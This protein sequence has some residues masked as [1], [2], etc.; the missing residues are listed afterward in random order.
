MNEVRASSSPSPGLASRRTARA[1]LPGFALRPGATVP[2]WSVVA[3]QATEGALLAMLQAEHFLHRWQGF[4]PAEDRA[5]RSLLRLYTER[6]HAP[7][8][9]DL[10]AHTGIG[11]LEIRGLLL[12]LKERDLVVLDAKNENIVGAYPFTDRD[13]GHRV[14]LKG[15]TLNAMCAV[16]ALGVGDM[17]GTDIEIGSHCPVCGGP[18]DIATRD[19]GRALGDVRPRTI[20]VWLG[21]HYEGGCAAS[22]L[23]AETAFF[24]SGD[25]LD[26]WLRERQSDGSGARLSAAQAL[27]AGRAIFRL[28]LTN[29]DGV[30]RPASDGSAP[31]DE[32]GT[33]G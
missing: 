15:Q 22:S 19:Q 31:T 27:E 1:A 13:T 8:V 20:V 21:L 24:C 2:D 28:S 6:G 9:A 32:R 16:D 18:I 7:T 12:R 29:G 23:C 26:A 33:F 25:H 11:D 10:A 30:D 17:C 5:R 3:S 14:R 4:G